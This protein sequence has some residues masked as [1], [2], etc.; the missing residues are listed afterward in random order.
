VAVAPAVMMMAMRVFRG[1][2][3]ISDFPCPQRRRA[4]I[5]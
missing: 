1:R 2:S 4:G 5:Y 3:G